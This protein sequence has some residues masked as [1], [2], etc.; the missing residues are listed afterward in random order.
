MNVKQHTLLLGPAER[1]D[2]IVD[3]TNFAGK[4][5]ILYNDAPAALPAGDPRND[6]YTGDLDQTSTGGAPTTQPGYGPNTRTIMQIKV[7]GVDSGVP[8]PV[9]AYNDT[10]FKALQKALPAAFAASQDTIIVPQTPYQA[11]YPG[12]IMPAATDASQY[13]KLQDTSFTFK[14]IGQNTAL[15]ME[16]QP[17][18]IIEDFTVDYGRMDAILGVEI[19]HTNIINQTSIIQAYIDPPTELIQGSDKATLIGALNDGT[20]IWK[21]THN[22]VDTH[23]IHVHLFNAQL[24]NRVGWDGQIYPPEPN[25][26][27]WKETIQMNPLQDIIIALRPI[28]MTLPWDLP[29]SVRLLDPSRPAGAKGIQFANVDPNGNPVTVTNDVVNFGWEYVWHCHLLGHEEN[30]MMRPIAFGVPPVTPSG[31]TATLKGGKIALTWVDNSL[32]E[33]NFVV[34]VAHAATG[35][36]TTLA[37][38]PG[39][40]GTGTLM[41]YTDGTYKA[42]GVPYYYQVLAVNNIGATQSSG[43]TAPEPG[44][45]MLTMESGPAMAG[46]PAGNTTLVSV[47]QA[48]TKNAPVI[49]TWAYA[50]AGD[51][52]GFVIQR[53]TNAA[54]TT[55]VTTFTAAAN[56]IRYSDTQT[57]AGTTYYYRVAASNALGNGLWSNSSSITAR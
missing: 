39:A 30:D 57:K 45:S 10:N 1:A 24:I 49:V 12:T 14:P 47:T 29:N 27:G 41:T 19:A 54:F 4:T 25:E 56:A 51:Q 44:Y 20:Q 22:G 28:T 26:L 6:Y 15:T 37:T 38:L 18:S 50:P 40:A 55:G 13:M 46:P 3:F 2:V 48:T 36:W 43:F 11:A 52:T 34:Q 16:T 17:K 53:A 35:P 21:I 23:A 7:D 5:L 42:K 8:G 31:L 33:T 32:S 9:D